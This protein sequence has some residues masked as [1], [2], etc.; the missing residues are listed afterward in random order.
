MPTS[1]TISSSIERVAFRKLLWVGPMAAVAA[2]VAVDVVFGIAGLF[3]VPLEVMAPPTY[4]TL[5]PMEV[6][7]IA[8]ATIPPAIGATIL[9]AILGRFTRRPFLIFQI[10]AA[11]FL[12]LSFGGPLSLPVSGVVKMVLGLI[13]IVA[14]GTIVG[15][16][17]TL[18]RE[19]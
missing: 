16:L 9:L 4:E 13:H 3:G 7:F 17:S 5:S 10:I 18:G 14:A 6:S 11:V 15:V 8:Q 12:L 1:S 2:F 19:R